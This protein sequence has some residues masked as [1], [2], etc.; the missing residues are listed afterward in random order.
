MSGIVKTIFWRLTPPSVDVGLVHQL[1]VV[2]Q[3]R[4]LF[5]VCPPD[6]SSKSADTPN[7]AKVRL[8][9]T[10]PANIVAAL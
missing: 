2:E 10:R 5:A 6:D 4:G 9:S 3:G 1:H 8:R 7:D